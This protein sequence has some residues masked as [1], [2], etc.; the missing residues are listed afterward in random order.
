[1]AEKTIADI[2]T[3]ETNPD[4]TELVAVSDAGADAKVQVQNLGK[5][6]KLDDLKSPDINTDLDATATTHG[7]MPAADKTKVDR[8]N[9][10]DG[11]RTPTTDTERTNWDNSIK[12]A[13]QAGFRWQFDTA[14]GAADPGSGNF[15]FDNVTPASITKT[16][17]S[18]TTQ[19]GL[20]LESLMQKILPETLMIAK[21]KH[22]TN[23]VMLFEVTAAADNGAWWTLTITPVSTSANF[24]ASEEVFI[25]FVAI[26]PL[27]ASTHKSGGTDAIKLHE[28][29]APDDNTTLDATSAL[30]GL[31]PKAD[32]AKVDLLTVP[33]AR[34]VISDAERAQLNTNT[35]NTATNISEIDGNR[36]IAEQAKAEIDAILSSLTHDQQ[37]IPIFTPDTLEQNWATVG[38]SHNFAND[39]T[40]THTGSSGAA[41]LTDS[42]QN[43]NADEHLGRKILNTTDGSIATI[44]KNTATTITG[45][46]TGGT[47][48]DWDNGDSYQI[49][50]TPPKNIWFFCNGEICQPMRFNPAD[51]VHYGTAFLGDG[52][53]C[54]IDLIDPA[55]NFRSVA[56]D[57]GNH[58][59][60]NNASTLTDST[61]SWTVDEHVNR[62]I[63]NLTDGSTGKITANTAT[64]IT[65]TLA[66]GDQD[67]W[68]TGDYYEII[69]RTLEEPAEKTAV[70]TRYVDPAVSEGS[71]SYSSGDPGNLKDALNDEATGDHIILFQGS[72]AAP[73]VV[74]PY[75]YGD[76]LSGASFDDVVIKAETGENPVV[77]GFIQTAITWTDESATYQGVYSTTN[78]TATMHQMHVVFN[79]NLE[80][81]PH[82]ASL[83]TLDMSY[84]FGTHDGAANASVLADS[85]QAW[86][87]DEFI[88][89]KVMN[90]TDGS[91]AIITDNDATTITA[92]LA[93]GT[94]NDWDVGDVYIIVPRDESGWTIN[95]G[96]LYARVGI[97]VGAHTGSSGSSTLSD[98]SQSWTVNEHVNRIVHNL[99]DGSWGTVT[100]NTATAVTATLANGTEN[101][102][103][104][105][106]VYIIV[107]DM[108]SVTAKLPADFQDG[109]KIFG[110]G[111][112]MKGLTL[113]GWGA[114][115]SIQSDGVTVTGNDFLVKDCIFRAIQYR[116]LVMN[117]TIKRLLVENCTFED[118]K[119]FCSFDDIKEADATEFQS[120]IS[121]EI[122][123]DDVEIVTIRNSSFREHMDAIAIKGDP[124][125]CNEVNVYNNTFT[126]TYGETM[127]WDGNHKQ[128]RRWKNV[129][130]NNTHFFSSALAKNGPYL[131]INDRFT[132]YGN[133]PFVDRDVKF[134]FE[135]Q[136]VKFASGSSGQCIFF[137]NTCGAPLTPIT[138]YRDANAWKVNN[139][140]LLTSIIMR[141][142]IF[143][144]TGHPIDE[145][146]TD[147]ADKYDMDYNWWYSTNEA[148]YTTELFRWENVGVGDWDGFRAASGLEANGVYQNPA[149][150][151]GFPTT[152]V[153]GEF[154]PGISGN[155]IVN[156][157]T[158]NMGAQ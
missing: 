121:T 12:A 24:S 34:T 7:L 120:E 70:R 139:G 106:D 25:S 63:R 30:H 46:L 67:D 60:A 15:R 55:G 19:T 155:T 54:V 26:T 87:N 52:V 51:G 23:K 131:V 101:D 91:E 132:G 42:T 4:G 145:E 154:I 22:D 158:T 156:V 62:A 127:D 69:P 143:E 18:E 53:A 28:L 153:T 99:T 130:T 73:T 39:L 49:V 56:Y 72:R 85:S 93:G 128:V 138:A 77:S 21:S 38:I 111:C 58:D 6:I 94:D 105:D 124:S 14:T 89:R 102:W 140:N 65:A 48:N 35:T 122:Q 79:G 136:G 32:K 64:T 37:V 92:P 47:E 13:D 45:T 83:S 135:Q 107:E 36:V 88:D 43:W 157:L 152:D 133:I 33:D 110:D 8:L 125:G 118:R 84:R 75:P 100:A 129:G 86:T 78:Y 11:P 98:T 103:D 81:I 150:V 112:M 1:M 104:H 123:I 50:H 148:G 137:N 57:S 66:G 90:I 116:G 146:E 71:G 27:H 108:T 31:M 113:E 134:P 97:V 149:L 114:G 82:R 44:T 41:I 141:N 10:P 119:R 109:F 5:G 61:Q 59:G 126:D 2:T 9:V 80:R 117:S 20:S 151:G 95:A 142:N 16:Y 74:L 144:T 76:L 68:D 96:K 40:G 147:N 17:I 3:E 29:A 115:A